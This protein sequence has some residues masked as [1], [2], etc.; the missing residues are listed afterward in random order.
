M[1]GTLGELARLFVRLGLTS[2]GGPAVHIAMMRDE[3]VRRRRWMSDQAFL[4][5]LG[6]SNLIPGPN[7]TELAIH[8]GRVRAGFPGLVVAGAC[9][10]LPAVAIVLGFAWAYVE[11]GK[12]P[13]GDAL[14]YGIEPM[15]IAIVLVALFG[16]GRTAVKDAWLAG[17][18]LASF[19]LYLAGL[20]E[21]IVLFGVGA[22]VMVGRNV[23]SLPA[24]APL[25]APAPL[26]ALLAQAPAIAVGLD[27]LFLVFLKVGALLYGSGYVLL[28]FLRGDLVENLGWLTQAQLVDA[29]AVGQMTPGPLF[30]TATFVGYVLAGLP[31][32]GVATFGIFLPSFVLVAATGP[33][34][35]RARTSSWMAAFVDGVNVAALG[36][37]AGVTWQLGREAIVDLPTTLLF[38]TALVI[39]VWFRPNSAWIVLAGAGAGLGLSYAGV[40]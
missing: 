13:P 1:A 24:G 27:R 25:F 20:N 7:S 3:V 38:V 11:Y 29:V 15:V 12:T 14:L 36:L 32:A 6:A 19:L 23:R 28:A 30:T 33:L 22:V 34:V 17:A 31:G 35:A 40:I 21:L 16:L 10:I 2:F 8:I 5:L 18:G 26:L 37:M 9:F 39:L 4:D